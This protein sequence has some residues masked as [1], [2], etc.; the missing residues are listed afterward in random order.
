MFSRKPQLKEGVH[1]FS[2]KKNGDFKDFIFATVT[3]V[4]E[5]KLEL[6]E[7]LKSS[8]SEK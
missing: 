5:E 4:E 1:V 3:G 8:W 6:V 7:S 2:V